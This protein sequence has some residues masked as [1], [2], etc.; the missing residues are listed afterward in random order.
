ML[1]RCVWADQV[2][3]KNGDKITGKVGQIA[4]G[5]MKF[6]SPVLGEITIDMAN[7]ESFS[8]DAPVDIRMKQNQ[9]T[10]TDKVTG[11]ATDYKTEGGRDVPASDVKVFNPPPAKWTGSVLFSGALARG[12]TDTFDLG[13]D[14]N[15]VYRRDV[16]E[17]DDRL[18]LGG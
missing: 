7:V 3:L 10:V 18:T 5:K 6:T 17:K 9:P 8:T 14:A 13:F 11:T 4:D 15:A 2:V 1:T 12:N 16:P